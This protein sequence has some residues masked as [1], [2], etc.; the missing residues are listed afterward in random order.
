M[1]HRSPPPNHRPQRRNSCGIMLLRLFWARKWIVLGYR[2]AS[3]CHCCNRCSWPWLFQCNRYLNGCSG[4]TLDAGETT[5]SNRFAR[6]EKSQQHDAARIA[7]RCR[8]R[9]EE[10]SHRVCTYRWLG[11]LELKLDPMELLHLFVRNDLPLLVAHVVATSTA[12]CGQPQA[13]S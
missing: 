4:V 7:L 3:Y 12:Q 1:P 9:D 8:M 2:P 6:S 10:A 5:P 11:N 13:G